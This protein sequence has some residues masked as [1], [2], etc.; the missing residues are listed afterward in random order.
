[1][2]KITAIALSTV[3]LLSLFMGGAYA[4]GKATVTQEAFYVRPYF[5]Y[6]AGEIYA[7]ITNTGDKPV[8]FN[9]GLIEL[10]N[11]DGDAIESS[12]LYSCY[13]AVLAPGEVGYLYNTTSV[14]EAEEISY[15]DDYSLT[16]T[17]KAENSKETVRLSS[18]GTFG[19]YQRS[20]YS[21]EYAM[22]ANV[23]NDTNEILRGVRV[24]Y[25]LYG[26]E[27]NLLYA[28]STELYSL[29]IPPAQTVEV[30]MSVDRRILEA[31]ESEG[32]TPERIVTIAYVE[33]EL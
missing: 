4:A 13:P 28:D 10:Y 6:H 14:K 16:I 17:G 20:K 33:N 22:F 32:V 25:A 11:P 24:V 21:T 15:I 27:D 12:N 1:M 5:D 31:W 3:L 30:R 2:K 8:V 7:E 23:T 19:E 26:A 29:G 9:G 18:E